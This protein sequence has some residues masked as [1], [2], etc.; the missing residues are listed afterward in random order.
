MLL[1]YAILTSWIISLGYG[2]HLA[3]IDPSLLPTIALGGYGSGAPIVFAL[4]WSKTSFA[5]TLLRLMQGWWKG[6]LWFIIV[7]MN[8]FLTLSVIFIWVSCRPLEKLINPA[9]PGTC[10]PV[11]VLVSY[12]TFSGGTYRPQAPLCHATDC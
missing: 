1:A 4:A 11:Q 10:W 9:V 8:I 3:A 7:S 12:A 2:K 5:L 6:V